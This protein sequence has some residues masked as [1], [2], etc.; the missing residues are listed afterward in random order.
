MMVGIS[1]GN[2]FVRKWIPDGVASLPII[3]LHDSLG[4][5]ELWRDFPAALAHATQRVVIAYDRLGFGKS[6][7]RTEPIEISFIDDEA[8]FN[9][10]AV[11]AALGIDK[12]ILFG[13]SVGGAM[14]LVAA[15]L[16]GDNCVAIISESALVFV[17]DCAVAEIRKAKQ[18]FADE[19]LFGKLAKWHGERTR[20]VLDAWT[21]MWL[22]DEFK[23][24]T[25]DAYLTQIH[26]P[27]LAIHGE[28]DEYGSCASPRHIIQSVRG[29]AKMEIIPASGHFPHRENQEKIV[30]LVCAFLEGNQIS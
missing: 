30:S 23:H 6:S 9:L 25:L 24:W 19:N 11:V 3:L 16:Q 27:L 7:L 22:S 8:R 17:E 13:H 18:D 4:S 21:G 5:V 14:A 15:A 10:P 2:I 29:P 20:W 12:Y 1:N 28:S 26:I